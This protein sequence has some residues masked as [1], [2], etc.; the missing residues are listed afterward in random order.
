MKLRRRVWQDRESPLEPDAWPTFAS[1][2]LSPSEHPTETEL[3]GA[4]RVAIAE[5]LSIHKREVLVAVTL[6]GIP[7]DVLAER[8]NAA[9]GACTRRCTTRAGSCAVSWPRTAST[10]PAASGSTTDDRMTALLIASG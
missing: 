10:S 5:R 7:I 4:L 6:N 9:S 3:L 8:L 1:Q 2:A